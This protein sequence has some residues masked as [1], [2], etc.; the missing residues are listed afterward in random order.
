ME[1]PGNNAGPGVKISHLGRRAL[2]AVDCLPKHSKRFS[3]FAYRSFPAG[4]KPI[5]RFRDWIRDLPSSGI[6]FIDI[7]VQIK[8]MARLKYSEHVPNHIPGLPVL[9]RQRI[10]MPGRNLPRGSKD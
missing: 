3:Y 9:A 1:A 5:Y 6:I 7:V 4:A 2:G 10:R 8:I